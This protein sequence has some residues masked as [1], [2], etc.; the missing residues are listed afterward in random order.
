MLQLASFISKI[1]HQKNLHILSGIEKLTVTLLH[2]LTD[3]RFIYP[4]TLPEHS[5]KINTE[6]K[7]LK[8]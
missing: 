2:L 6:I 3:T 7:E 1:N 5:S 4:T 8:N